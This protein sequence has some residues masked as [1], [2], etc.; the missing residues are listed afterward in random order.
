MA[1]RGRSPRTVDLLRFQVDEIAHAAIS[2]PDEEERLVAEESVLAQVAVL[3]SAL[4]GAREALAGSDDPGARGGFGASD[5]LGF[6]VSELSAHG[7]LVRARRAL[8]SCPG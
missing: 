1:I 8:E 4:A 2:D 3:K 5:L 7:A 6:A